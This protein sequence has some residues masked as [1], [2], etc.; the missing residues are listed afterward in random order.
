[1]VVEIIDILFFPYHIPPFSLVA[2]DRLFSNHH[3][4][5]KIPNQIEGRYNNFCHM[6]D[7]VNFYVHVN[8]ERF[9]VYF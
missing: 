5:H 9:M 2:N 4:N 3:N 6:N 1:M 8:R 7:H